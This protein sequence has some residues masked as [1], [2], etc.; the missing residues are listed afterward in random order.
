MTTKAEEF[1][2]QAEELAGRLRRQI[3]ESQLD[4]GDFFMT[5]AD[6]AATYEVSRTV[7]REAVG[8]LKS[9]G[10]LEG[11]KRKGLI[12]R[13]PDP[14]R[15]LTQTLPSLISSEDD[16][17][18]LGM[19]RYALEVGSIELAIQHATEEQLE[20]LARIVS[21]M[22]AAFADADLAESFV[23]LDLQFHALILS[24]TGSRM[25]SGMRNLLVDF[26]SKV[27]RRGNLVAV[28]DRMIWEHRELYNAIR[29][30]DVERARTMIRMH[31]TEWF[32]NASDA[33]SSTD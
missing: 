32:R 28:A 22:E 3:Q 16:L 33:P 4:D 13:R 21:D 9:L 12:V 1:R 15:L 2:T 26:F 7:A 31:C 29:A 11:R 25:I 24:M 30:R 8:R 19:L 5:E 17:R 6:L 23:D 14:I 18:E 10:M 20:E 27:P